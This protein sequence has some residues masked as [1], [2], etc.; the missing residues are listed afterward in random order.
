MCFQ[1]SLTV[2]AYHRD[3]SVSAK[4]ERLLAADLQAWLCSED[5]LFSYPDMLRKV[6]LLLSELFGG[7]GNIYVC[8]YV[9]YALLS[10]YVVCMYV[11]CMLQK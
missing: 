10:M 1:I 8:M 2:S 6:E 9:R 4:Q 5:P 11:G 7:A 3:K